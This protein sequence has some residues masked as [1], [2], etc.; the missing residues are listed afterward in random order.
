M[1]EPVAPKAFRSAAAFRA[2]LERHH[3]TARELVVR[4]F[5]RHARAEGMTYREA[6]D[7]ALCF[8][9]IDGVRRGHDA[10]SFTVRF[11]PRQPKSRWSA[12]NRK[13]AA[14]LQ[15]A[16]RMR[17]SGLA[18]LQA[19]QP[20]SYS[21]EMDAVD[22]DAASRRA[23]RANARAWGYYERQPP[24]YR[25]TSARWVM[26][27]KRAET[28]ARRLQTLIDCSARETPIPPL[29]RTPVPRQRS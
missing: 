14:E 2:W 3:E 20:S 19:G 25:R 21:Y 28:R 4:L 11:T 17:P 13:R 12:V 7:E 10:D 6:L 1:T 27:A 16:G 15:G 29:R 26:S 22:L 9:W 24:W 8:G 23:F 5:R 18:A